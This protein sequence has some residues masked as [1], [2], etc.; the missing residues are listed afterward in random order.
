MVSVD[1]GGGDPP[2]VFVLSLNAGVLSPSC[3]SRPKC[4][5]IPLD[6]LHGLAHLLLWGELNEFYCFGGVWNMTGRHVV[7]LSGGERLFSVRVPNLYTALQDVA[8]VRCLA[9]VTKPAAG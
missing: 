7:S 8:P 1:H 9:S 5:K 2:Q 3:L 4:L 6:Y